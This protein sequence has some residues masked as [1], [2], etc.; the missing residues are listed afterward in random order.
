MGISFAI[1]EVKIKR[2]I[3]VKWLII[4]AFSAS[5]ALVGLLRISTRRTEIGVGIYDIP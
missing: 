5:M 2:L 4:F 3:I 1:E